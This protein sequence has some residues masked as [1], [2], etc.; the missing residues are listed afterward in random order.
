MFQ[1]GEFWMVKNYAAVNHG[2]FNY[3]E[4]ILCLLVGTQ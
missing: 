1:H 3:E 4:P 2:A